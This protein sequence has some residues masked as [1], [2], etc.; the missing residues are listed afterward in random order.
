MINFIFKIYF[1]IDPASWFIIITSIFLVLSGTTRKFAVFI[2][3]HPFS[4]RISELIG[5]LTWGLGISVSGAAV[6]ANPTWSCHR[7]TINYDKRKEEG[8]KVM[9]IG[10][11][12]A[13][14]SLTLLAIS[15]AQG[16]F[17]N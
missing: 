4:L 10:A 14:V 15:L 8:E 16:Y 6:Y 1:T 7:R 9:E 12:V 11:N 13:L 17:Y 3:K 5:K 2:L